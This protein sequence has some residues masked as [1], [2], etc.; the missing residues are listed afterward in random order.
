MPFISPD[1]RRLLASGKLPDT[2]GQ[3]CY[4]EYKKM[5]TAWKAAPRW[6]TAHKIYKSVLDAK[7]S[8]SPMIT[9]ELTAKDLAWQMF[10]M[11]RILPYESLKEQENGGIE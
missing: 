5:L 3:F 11:L 8:A 4:L 2:V 6:T 7:Q 9:D 10:F 1:E